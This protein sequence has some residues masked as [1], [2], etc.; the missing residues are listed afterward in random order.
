MGGFR[1]AD[2]GAADDSDE[3]MSL[4]D[5]MNAPQRLD[6]ESID[7]ALEELLARLPEAGIA[8]VGPDGRFVDLPAS[9]PR[10]AQPLLDGRAGI[11][12]VAPDQRAPVLNQFL[13]LA[14]TG[15]SSLQVVTSAGEP[16]TYYLLDCTETHGVVIL[17]LAVTGPADESVLAIPEATPIVPRYGRIWRTEIAEP[18]RIEPAITQMLGFTLADYQAQS[19]SEFIHPDDS[20]TSI[21]NWFDVI[22]APPGSVRRWR[23]RSKRKDG[24]WA[25]MEFTNTN[26]LDDPL[27]P[28]VLT[29][30]VDISLEMKAADEI[31]ESRELLRTLTDSLPV[32]VLQLGVDMG[33]MYANG[34]LY[35][36]LG[37]SRHADL[38][39]AV[40]HI[41]EEDRER[42]AEALNDVLTTRADVD[43]EAQYTRPGE[44][45]VRYLQ[46][47]MRALRGRDD[48]V[49]GAILSVTDTTEASELRQQLEFKATYDALTECLN[50]ASIMHE[51]DRTVRNETSGAGTAVVFVDLDGFKAINDRAGHAAGDEILR[52]AAER[53]R[54]AVRSH[55]LVGRM[56]GDEFVVLCPDV[57]DPA[58]AMEVAQRIATTVAGPV[59][60]GSRTETIALSVGVA[61]TSEG[62]LDADALVARADA[63]MYEAKR[64]ADGQP[65]LASPD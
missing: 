47:A 41:D 35:E 2:H 27:D 25:W 14:E 61:W 52:T 64:N 37:L 46:V 55:D 12:L 36:L 43:L 11:D 51:I 20:T 65:V 1:H 49:T 24:T 33:V 6:A 9:V 15:A 53:F 28:H 62:A 63:A 45:T 31:W 32:G 57:A 40:D 4:G 23:G 39:D 18:L 29:E 59:S 5:P 30:M 44:R 19:A 58:R 3:H 17:L 8:A 54:G 21:T 16:A 38:I 34:R 48:E 10:G 42:L 60:V 50:R 26:H 13:A 7:R 22:G 56:G